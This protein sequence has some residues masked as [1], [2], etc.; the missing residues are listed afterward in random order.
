MRTETNQLDVN[1]LQKN[2]GCTKYCKQ[3]PVEVGFDLCEAEP[4]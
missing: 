4:K 3:S 1:S 2:Q